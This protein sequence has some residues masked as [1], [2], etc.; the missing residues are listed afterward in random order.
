MQ[1]DGMFGRGECLENGWRSKTRQK[2]KLRSYRRVWKD[3]EYR[4]LSHTKVFGVYL[5][6]FQD[7]LD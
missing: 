1:D 7:L 4:F 2:M 3:R 5:V 6:V